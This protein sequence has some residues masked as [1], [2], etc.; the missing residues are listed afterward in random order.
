MCLI[1]EDN[2]IL[3]P[4]S[5]EDTNFVLKLRNDVRVSNNFFSDPPLYDFQHRDWINNN[6]RNRLDFIVE[7]GNEKVGRIS[8][9]KIDYRHQKANYGIAILPDFSGKGIAYKASKMLFDYVFTN[10]PI[11]KINLEVFSDNER[12][13]KLY[14]KL[15]FVQEGYFKREYFKN[16]KWKGVIRMALFSKKW[17]N[18]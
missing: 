8:L 4:I 15:G 1:S 16:G 12:A 18:R 9:D 6:F 7:Y 17:L 10:L 2:I 3:R 5:S 11:R 13:I 14:K